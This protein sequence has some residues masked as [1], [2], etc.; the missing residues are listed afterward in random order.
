[1]AKLPSFV[2]FETNRLWVGRWHSGFAESEVEIY[3]DPEVTQWTG[4]QTE[5]PAA[6]MEERI[7]GLVKRNQKSF[8]VWGSWPAFLKHTNQLVVAMLMKPLPGEGGNFTE[9]I[10]G[11]WHLARAHWG[12]YH[13]GWSKDD[14]VGV[15]PPE[16]AASLC[17]DGSEQS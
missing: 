7:A 11:G 10:E 9:E 8:K 14:R 6:G 12:V 4:G 2:V 1:M 15:R 5:T 17:R 3:G 16:S 13:E